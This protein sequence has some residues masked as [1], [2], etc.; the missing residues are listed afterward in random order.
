MNLEAGGDSIRASCRQG[1]QL[2]RKL[3]V[4]GVLGVVGVLGD[5][6]VQNMHRALIEPGAVLDR[7]CS[8]RRPGCLIGDG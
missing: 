6:M 4:L 1:I 5:L 8:R 7:E 3:D 2:P